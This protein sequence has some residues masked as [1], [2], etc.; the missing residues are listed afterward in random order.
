[1]NLPLNHK[2]E[3]WLEEQPISF[4]VPGHKNMTIG[5]LNTMD[6]AMDITE[7]TDFDDLHHPEAVLKESMAA[8]DK[9]PEYDAYYLVNGTTSGILSVIQAAAQQQQPIIM[10]RNVHKSVFHGLDLAQKTADILPMTLSETTQQYKA[11]L[12]M[13]NQEKHSL[14][15][16]TYPNYYGETFD[17]QTFIQ[18][19]HACHTPVLVDEAHGAHFGLPGFPHSSLTYGADYVVQSYHKSLP[20]LT[21]SSVIFIH[22]SAPYREQVLEYLTYFQSSSPSYLLMAGL[23]RAHHFYKMYDST[24]FFEKRRRLMYA[25]SAKGFEVCEMDDP[26]KLTVTYP[27]YSGYEVQQWLEAQN[28]YLELADEQQ[29][30]LV[31]PMWHEGDRFPFDLLLE[32]IQAI[33]VPHAVKGQ[34]TPCPSM[35][36]TAGIYQPA[37]ITHMKSAALETTAGKT[38]AQH[39]VPYPPGIPVFYKGE[40]VSG[41]M[42]E[43]MENWLAQGIRVEGITNRT[44]KIKD[45]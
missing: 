9:H 10:G 20:A 23:E 37:A 36:K 3:T 13:N 41:E 8:I 14:A 15:I 45:E 2:L 31:L 30:L 42:I 40:V 26:L 28:I 24:Q 7:I 38:L 16:V 18:Q 44:I 19:Q 35:P 29:G 6:L 34:N 5:S 17:I 43:I 1:M 39:I 33:Q 12:T 21:M 32:R 27:G 11:P 25:L 4:H 22:K